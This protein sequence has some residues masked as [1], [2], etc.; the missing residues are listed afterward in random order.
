MNARLRAMSIRIGNLSEMRDARWIPIPAATRLALVALVAFLPLS[1]LLAAGSASV[2]AVLNSS[3]TTVGQP[4]QLQIK[5]SGSASARPPGE[6]S[7]D[8][9]DIRYSGQS[10]LL[11]GHNFQFSYSSIFSHTVMP[12]KAGTFKSPPQTVQ[13][14][15]SALR[16]PELTLNVA[17]DSSAPSSRSGQRSE[18][19]DTSKIAFVELTLS[20][21]SGYVGEIIPAIVRLGF[22]VRTPIESLG[23]GIEITGQ[24]FTTQKM[25]EPRQNVET[26]NGKTFQT[27]TFKTAISPARSGKIQIGPAEVN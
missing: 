14:S 16:T 25:R 22:N 24:G 2:T 17:A 21:T 23:N 11:E 12:L 1:H 27:F 9:L 5:I 3:E 10:Q 7:V 15:G 19:V 6:I 20:K 4:V 8:G 18:T 26:I 13:A